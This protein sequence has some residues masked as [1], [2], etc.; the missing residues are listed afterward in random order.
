MFVCSGK[1]GGKEDKAS[2][3][4]TI[5]THE[6]ALPREG[7]VSTIHEKW[8]PYPKAIQI[9]SECRFG[10]SQKRT[11]V[12][13]CSTH[14]NNC[15]KHVHKVL[16]TNELNKRSSHQKLVQEV[17]LD[18]TKNIEVRQFMVGSGASMHVTW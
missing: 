14:R 2:G 7:R 5:C 1:A 11:Y 12:G 8:I 10:L 13:H 3:A 16:G 15:H 17:I 6:N 9:E 18:S 4:A